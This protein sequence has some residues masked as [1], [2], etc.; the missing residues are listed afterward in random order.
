MSHTDAVLLITAVVLA[1]AL[2]AMIVLRVRAGRA[3]RN[4]HTGELTRECSHCGHSLAPGAIACPTC[5]SDMSM[6]IV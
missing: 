4:A 6:F 2:V 3:R 1:A 5:G